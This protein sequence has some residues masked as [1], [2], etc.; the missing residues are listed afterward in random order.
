ME[1]IINIGTFSTSN[2][3]GQNSAFL[4]FNIQG[5]AFFKSDL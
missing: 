4:G 1:R 2:E 5:T 3:T